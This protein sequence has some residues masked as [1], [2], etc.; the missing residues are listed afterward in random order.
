MMESERLPDGTSFKPYFE[1]RQA[2]LR[3]HWEVRGYKFEKAKQVLVTLTGAK[4]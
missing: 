4:A 2:E 1:R 3:A